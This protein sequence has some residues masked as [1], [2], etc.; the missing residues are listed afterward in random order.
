MDV[1][2][3]LGYFLVF[4]G[5]LVFVHELGHF[6][7]AKLL[8][9]K[10]LKFS[11]GFGP[12]VFGFTR[13]ETEYRVSWIPLGGYVKMAGEQPY[14][15]LA[16]EEARRGFLAQAPWK[17]MLIVIAGPAFNL[18]FPI[19]AYFFVFLGEREAITTRI[20]SVKPNLP[21]AAAGLR[22]GDRIVAVDGEQVETFEELRASLTDTYD[23]QISL[24]V[25]RQGKTFT[26]TLTPARRV[27]SNP[28]E[29]VTRG[30]IGISP[31]VRAAMVGVP[32]GSPAEKAGLR[33]FD[34]ILS[35]NGK[36][37]SDELELFE[38]LGQETGTLSIQVM[39]GEVV[40]LPGAAFQVPQVLTITMERQKGEG[41][42]ALGVERSDL[43]VGWVM[44]GSPAAAAG[45][46]P[47]DRLLAFNG[48]VITS[49]DVLG[50]ALEEVGEK[51]FNLSWSSGG[52]EKSAELR[53]IK[54]KE[55][56]ELGTVTEEL[57]LGV[58]VRPGL[59]V[60]DSE[61]RKTIYMGPK[62]ALVASA[63]TVPKVI[64]QTALVIGKLFTGEVPFGSVGGPVMLAQ[65]ATRSAEGGYKMFLN[66]MAVLSVN[67]G[68]INLLPI[69]ILDGFHLLAAVWEGVRRRPIPVRAR[70]IANMVGLA[71][72]AVIMV[73]VL[74]NDITR[75]LR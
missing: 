1:L 8:N 25:E 38:V 70:E 43:Y 69:P 50:H 14:E 29:K 60:A 46:R 17:R 2:Q 21:A 11:I 12:K 51:P 62:D 5:V 58:R 36:P 33:T 26:T 4:L 73:A 49:P 55:E 22:P 68:L 7:V 45:I 35:V 9:V 61:E 66:S 41:L 75:L 74:R 63:R 20:G 34:R 48:Q 53:Q 3:K 44:P 47:G 23:R 30:M 59:F 39:R 18:V 24:E 19:I 65:I 37:A 32:A 31:Q 16:P 28:I 57:T 27:E 13:G 64:R 72:L 52:Q 56:D 67:L 15:E 42:S 54:V 6:L 40:E 10:V 71:L